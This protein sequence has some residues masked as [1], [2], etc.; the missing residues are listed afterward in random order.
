MTIE[1]LKT[2]IKQVGT[3]KEFAKIVGVSPEHLCRL[4]KKGEVNAVFERK[5]KIAFRKK[6]ARDA[7]KGKKKPLR[8][9]T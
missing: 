4:L 2:K 1:E 6:I 5:I 3:Q 8:P 9:H 7:L